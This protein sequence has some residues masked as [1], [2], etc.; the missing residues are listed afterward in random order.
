MASKQN[1]FD[2]AVVYNEMAN[3]EVGAYSDQR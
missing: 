3:H 1:S 2:Q